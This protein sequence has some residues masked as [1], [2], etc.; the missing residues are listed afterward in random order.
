MDGKWLSTLVVRKDFDSWNS[1]D[2]V[3][4]EDSNYSKNIQTELRHKE[5]YKVHKSGFVIKDMGVG[6]SKLYFGSNY[7]S[8]PDHVSTSFSRSK[9]SRIKGEYKT[10]MKALVARAFLP[11]PNNRRIAKNI[12]DNIFNNH[13]DNLE[14]V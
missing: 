8:E 9:N 2:W 11:N 10:Y 4:L 12:D 13:I 5:T 3:Y 7:P 1:K 6:Y 14:W